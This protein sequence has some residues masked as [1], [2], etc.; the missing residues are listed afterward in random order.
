MRWGGATRTVAVSLKTPVSDEPWA[1][2]GPGCCEGMD[3]GVAPGVLFSRVTRFSGVGRS[4]VVSHQGTARCFMP[5]RTKP[6]VS[7][8]ASDFI[9]SWWKLPT[10]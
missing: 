7:G 3:S 10:G 4:S 9:I 5:S 6:G 1:P 2:A 8:G